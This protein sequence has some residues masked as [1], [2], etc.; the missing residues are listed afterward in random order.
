MPTKRMLQQFPTQYTR[1][2]DLKLHTKKAKGLRFNFLSAMVISD[3]NNLENDTVHAKSINIFK[4]KLRHEWM[5]HT[6][7]YNHL[8]T[9]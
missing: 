3:W 4:A 7:L 2:H 9:L 1:G 5:D 8:F 6:E